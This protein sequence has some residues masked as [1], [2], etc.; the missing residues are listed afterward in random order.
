MNKQGPQVHDIFFEQYSAFSFDKRKKSEEGKKYTRLLSNYEY[1]EYIRRI[2]NESEFVTDSKNE[3]YG[4]SEKNL[5]ELIKPLFAFHLSSIR[6]FFV[7]NSSY[8]QIKSSKE[9]HMKYMS[10]YYVNITDAL[11]DSVE[12]TEGEFINTIE[13]KKFADMLEKIVYEKQKKSEDLDRKRLKDWIANR[14][15]SMKDRPFIQYSTSCFMMVPFLCFDGEGNKMVDYYCSSAFLGVGTFF[16]AIFKNKPSRKRLL[17][18]AALLS[19]N[20][21]DELCI[22]G[23][24]GDNFL[25]LICEDEKVKSINALYRKPNQYS[26]NMFFVIKE[27]YQM[28]FDKTSANYMKLKEENKSMEKRLL[29]WS[30]GCELLGYVL[31]KYSD[32]DDKTESLERLFYV[33]EKV[34]ILSIFP[35]N[36]SIKGLIDKRIEATNNDYEKPLCDYETNLVKSI[37][38][39]F[40]KIMKCFV[41]YI[42]QLH[43]H[44]KRKDYAE[45]INVAEVLH[46]DDYKNESCWKNF[47]DSKII[48]KIGEFDIDKYDSE[49]EDDDDDGELYDDI[50]EG[51][52]WKTQE[53][54]Q[55]VSIDLTEY[56]THKKS[57]DSK[58]L[59]VKAIYSIYR[60]G[61]KSIEVNIKSDFLFEKKDNYIISNE[62]F[63]WDK[64][65]Y[66]E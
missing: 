3:E 50:D 29:D 45:G 33:I 7:N 42:Y 55:H 56:Y 63:S 13:H 57:I 12:K 43:D 54:K 15:T 23:D 46:T 9:N 38:F 14:I 8:E 2:I 53:K 58:D 6:D 19:L 31:S 37:L 17:Q 41:E 16:M 66:V 20:P 22:K 34:S 51:Y 62:I 48:E 10:S 28:L 35:L 39:I 49:E 24:F 65:P 11:E 30:F 25:E 59:G 36:T 64:I 21:S 61:F 44:K 5:V 32:L 26:S 47:F 27:L 1:I 52:F 60:S 40:K 18:V 4:L